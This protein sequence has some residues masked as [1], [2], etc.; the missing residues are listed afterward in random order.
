M[1]VEVGAQ[2]DT[3]ED[4]TNA[5]KAYEAEHFVNLIIRDT[6]KVEAA[7]KRNQR[8][9]YN[10]AIKYSDISYCCTYGG[11]KYVSHSTGKRNHKTIKQACPFSLKVRA[12]VDGQ[13]LFIREMSSLHNHEISEAEFRLHPKQRKLDINSQEEIANLL[14]MEPDKKLLRDK[15][16]QI[17]GKVILMKDIHNIKTR[18][19]NPKLKPGVPK[20]ESLDND[21]AAD[22]SGVDMEQN[23]CESADVHPQPEVDI[24]VV[25]VSSSQLTNEQQHTAVGGP[26]ISD[27]PINHH[28]Y[29]D[30]Q[31]Y[32]Q[33]NNLYSV[34]TLSFPTGQ[35]YGLAAQ[36]FHQTT[37]NLALCNNNAMH[38]VQQVDSQDLGSSHHFQHWT[39][40][41]DIG[42]QAMSN[43][44]YQT[45]TALTFT[46][47]HNS[48]RLHT[49][50]QQIPPPHTIQI[51]CPDSV[52][53]VLL[54]APDT[55]IQTNHEYAQDPRS[56]KPKKRR[57]REETSISVVKK[58]RKSAIQADKDNLMK[59]YFQQATVNLFF[60]ERLKSPGNKFLKNIKSSTL[61][62]KMTDKTSDSQFHEMLKPLAWLFGKWTSQEGKGIY[63]TISDFTYAE[64]AEFHPIGMKP[65]VEYRLYSW[66]PE[67]NVPLHRETGFIRIK[68]E[69]NHIAFMAAHNLGVVEIQEGEV[70]GQELTVETTSLGR[71]SFNKPPE[72]KLLKRTLSRKGNELEQVILMQTNKTE[73]TEHLRITFKKVD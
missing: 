45:I 42:R 39:T 32:Q 72:V 53:A 61:A 3:Y 50:Q 71:T 18:L 17:T 36:P 67:N 24:P 4:L 73:T 6:R 48:D 65:I 14:S 47:P 64:E 9:T 34:N 68:P 1:A 66:K 21:D 44:S 33:A 60:N 54:D 49:V 25:D 23:M 59:K 40:L 26:Q 35:F 70:Q 46:D 29:L 16:M 58:K 20:R 57:W 52:Q 15:L 41:E 51:T 8:K 37:Q 63:P 55:N 28:C 10:A 30:T 56:S 22:N 7:A 13:R 62:P 12:T 11:K 5:I 2:F 31:T 19:V 27:S 69:S 38:N 43:G